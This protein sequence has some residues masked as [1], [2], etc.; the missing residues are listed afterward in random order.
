MICKEQTLLT[1]KRK[2]NIELL[3]IVAMVMIVGSHFAAHGGFHFDSNT[4]TLPRLWWGVIAMGGNFGVDVFVLISGYFLI[5]NRSL[6]TKPKKIIKLWGQILF[7]SLVLFGFA[8]LIGKGNASPKIIIQALFPIIFSQWWF[9]STYFVMY[10][11]HPYLN[12]MLQSFSQKE[13]QG[14]ILFGFILWSV[15]PTFTSSSFQSNALIEFVLFYSIAGY[16]RLFGFRS[17]I[18]SKTWFGL[19]LIFSVLTY[20]S[21]VAFILIGTKYELFLTHSRHFYLRNSVLTIFRATC[22]FMM[23]LTMNIRTNRLINRVSSAVFGV[24]LLHDNK[25]LRQFLWNDV[26]HNANFQNTAYIIPYSLV[27][28]LTVYVICTLIELFRISFLEK[29]LLRI[30][31]TSL[32]KVYS[33][34]EKIAYWVKQLIFGTE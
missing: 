2:T 7:Y 17:Q 34:S 6:I 23:F 30:V 20:L 21:Y 25:I 1:D 14:F 32:G 26:F 3:R 22:F 11:I 19:W 16:I 24:Y 10:L 15:I 29:P 5:E 12:R 18:S 28:I 31:D 13:Y 33:L 27:V 9:A 8:F 4:I